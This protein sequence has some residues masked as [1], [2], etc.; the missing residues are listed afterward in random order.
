MTL[1]P[2]FGTHFTQEIG[3]RRTCDLAGLIVITFSMLYFAMSGGVGRLLVAL[4]E[5][6]IKAY[7]EL[8][9]GGKGSRDQKNKNYLSSPFDAACSCHSTMAC[10]CECEPF[11]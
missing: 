3:Y 11:F 4:I 10:S 9:P 6:P 5:G 2:Y 1:V 7:K 8:L